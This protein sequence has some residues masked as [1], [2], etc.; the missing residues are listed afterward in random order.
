MPI[1][2]RVRVPT[3][4][5][6]H[7][8]LRRACV[9][10]W[11]VPVGVASGLV[12]AAAVVAVV[13]GGSGPGLFLFVLLVAPILRSAVAVAAPVRASPDTG[14]GLRL[15]RG[16]D[17]ELWALVDDAV[18]RTGG[19][20]PAALLLT[21]DADIRLL[22]PERERELA[23]G[24]PWL[25]ADRDRLG[26]AMARALAAAEAGARS[27]RDRAF[28]ERRRRVAEL[29]AGGGYGRLWRPQ[30]R[31]MN[32]L[33]DAVLAAR[34]AAADAVGA[35]AGGE[36]PRARP[37]C[38]DFPVFWVTRVAPCLEAGFAPPL[39]DGWRAYIAE[40]RRAEHDAAVETVLE[41]R[42]LAAL[43]PDA[44]G[45]VPLSW[46]RAA[47]V[48]WLP[49]L[50]A[51]LAES[52]AEPEPFRVADLEHAVRHGRPVDVSPGRWPDLV[53]AALTL[54]LVR[55]GWSV[56]VPPDGDFTVAGAGGLAF[57]PFALCAAL[58]A[59][60]GAEDWRAFAD[61]A[62]ID[63]LRVAVDEHAA[64]VSSGGWRTPTVVPSAAEQ[65]VELQR[66]PERRLRLAAVLLITALAAPIGIALLWVGVTGSVSPGGRIAAVLSG[67][68]FLAANALLAWMVVPP[69]LLSGVLI[70]GADSMRI[71]HR[72]LL[73]EPFTIPR[74]AVRTV[75]IDAGA[76]AVR[77]RLPVGHTEASLA[78]DPA[79]D[80][81]LYLWSR[82]LGAALVP[83]IGTGLE[84]PN[85]AVLVNDPTLAPRMRRVRM[86]GP[87]PGEALT[88]ILLATTD[89]SH[90]RRALTDW[91]VTRHGRPADADHVVSGF[92]G[93][94]SFPGDS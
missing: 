28:A 86:T 68:A 73:K 22:A 13:T 80:G 53:A 6:A 51:A 65:R 88:G 87:I 64:P 38:E 76:R 84:V 61:E 30:F 78:L 74:S 18:A 89:P 4:T 70:V 35:S 24:L 81:L 43:L 7:R 92:L 45:L 91:T 3:T 44:A 10:S 71:E 46:D 36:D 5:A 94:S 85:L 32:V 9:L 17:A 27:P 34:G 1:G 67:L 25:A 23:L 33:F 69:L 20:P 31:L 8:G 15:A 72:G 75:I 41:R 57:N 11:A 79:A 49:R 16:E 93:T 52:G 63:D 60:T 55:A 50:R 59:G 12:A 62:Q 82:D 26:H 39:L 40:A 47:E 58:T 21:A 2:V 54:A 48:V 29:V 56:A 19:A 77:H 14:R 83:L 37:R 90:A 42:L 66:S